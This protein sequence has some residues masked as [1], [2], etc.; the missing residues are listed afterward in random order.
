MAR[1]TTERPSP[2]VFKMPEKL[3]AFG[4]LHGHADA[5]VRTLRALELVDSHLKWSGGRTHL[6]FDGDLLDRG[7]EERRLLDLLMRLEAE[8]FAVGGRVHVLLGNHE[9]MNLTHDLRYVPPEGFAAFAADE[10]PAERHLLWRA[11]LARRGGSETPQLHKAFERSYPPGYA[12]R[13]LAFSHQ[14]HYG[15]WLMSKPFIVRIGGYLFVH[16]GL[17]EKV[18][19]L[20]I[21]EINRRAHKQLRRWLDAFDELQSHGVLDPLSDFSE[22]QASARAFLAPAT[23]HPLRHD[24]ALR[25]AAVMLLDLDASLPFALDGPVWYRGNSLESERVERKRLKEVLSLLD[26]QALLV[27]H[28]PTR[29]AAITTRFE[30]SLYRIDV[31]TTYGKGIKALVIEGKK[32]CAYDLRRGQC[33]ATEVEAPQGERWSRGLAEQADRQI[34]TFLRTAQMRSRRPLGRG[35][36]KPQLVQLELDRVRL[37]G[38][39]KKVDETKSAKPCGSRAADRYLHEV[40]AYRLDRLLGQSMVPVTT[41]REID[42]E[43]GSMQLWVEE[44]LDQQDLDTYGLTPA[45]PASLQAQLQ[46]ARV[47]DALIGN[48]DRKRSDRLFLLESSRLLLIDHSRA[49]CT[50]PRVDER[51]LSSTCRIEPELR[52]ALSAL[53]AATL[54]REL[55]R[56]LSRVQRRALLARRDAI[57]ERCGGNASPRDAS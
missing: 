2:F 8:A 26:A 16:G 55:G 50:D 51:L 31:G 12:A 43:E 1:A 40:A 15:S 57:L 32:L 38:L 14:A 22:A 36:T 24:R 42:G 18:A 13:T 33:V 9:V 39:F 48:Y 23:R 28:T 45:N 29:D 3:V 47:F 6:L 5:L 53:N 25:R 7:P 4:D 21:D 52:Q 34:E 54:R 17:T 19:Q 49:F 56:Y 37:R 35:S 46:Q 20:G 11:Y 27:G 44:A 41:L 10:T 30:K